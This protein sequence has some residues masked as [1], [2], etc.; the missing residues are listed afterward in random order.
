MLPT[1]AGSDSLSV[2]VP[3]SNS[4]SSSSDASPQMGSAAWWAALQEDN[5]VR[6]WVTEDV[7][8]LAGLLVQHPLVRGGSAPPPP[9]SAPSWRRQPHTPPAKPHTQSQCVLSPSPSVVLNAHVWRHAR[10]YHVSVHTCVL[11][12]MRVACCVL[13]CTYICVCVCL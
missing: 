4:S 6:Q 11:R 13:L 9:L 3:V 5:R 12:H 7:V 1:P 2:A 10:G 8:G